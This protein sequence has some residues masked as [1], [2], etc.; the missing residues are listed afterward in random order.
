MAFDP[1][2][3]V[4]LVVL[5]GLVIFMFRN[6]RKRQ[7]AAAELAKQVTVGAYVMTN[8]G[9]YGTILDIDEDKNII[10]LET[11]PGHSVKVHRQ[12]VNRVV[13]ETE[14]ELHE[15]E[16]SQDEVEAEEAYTLKD[17]PE[18]GERIEKKDTEASVTDS[19]KK[20][21][22]EGTAAE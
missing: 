8:F 11:A 4:M 15:T 9:L 2:T 16:P 20:T 13:D 5:A 19:T 22:P 18:Y 1:L 3:I 7:K 17:A 6:S 14:A 10:L 12:T 21:K